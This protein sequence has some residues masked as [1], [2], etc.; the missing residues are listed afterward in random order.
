MQFPAKILQTVPDRL[1]GWE[2]SFTVPTQFSEK[3]M[4]ALSVAQLNKS[5][6]AEITQAVVCNVLTKCKYPTSKQVAVVAAKVVE[7]I[8]GSKDFIGVGHVS[9]LI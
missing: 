6:R 3:T 4:A 8:P 2:D 1:A 9:C 7:K 5:A